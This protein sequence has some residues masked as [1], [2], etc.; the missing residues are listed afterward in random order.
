MLAGKQYLLYLYVS[1]RTVIGQ[2]SGSYSQVWPCFVN[3][4]ISQFHFASLI[5]FSLLAT[6][7]ALLLSQSVKF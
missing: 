2:F 3:V 1:M 4:C 6:F 5:K 7:I